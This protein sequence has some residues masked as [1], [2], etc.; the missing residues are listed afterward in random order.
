M[1][2]PQS[3]TARA[4]AADPAVAGLERPTPAGANA[5]GFGS[6]V[7]AEALR[8]LDIPYIALTPGASYR[9]LHD[10]IVNYLGNSKPQM[11]LCL[12]EEAAIAIAQ[13]YAKVTGKAMVTAVHSN[14]GLMHATMAIFNAW[15]DRMPV[16]VL[17]AT[18]P[19]DA[20]KRRPWIDWIHTSRDQGALIREYTKWD[21]QPA[22]P[23]AAREA[24]LRGTWIANTAPQG[25]VYI[26]F[27][28]EL[29]ESK[30]S[31]PLPP[32]DV[33]R[34]MPEVTTAAPAEL[35]KQAA[36]TLK[37]AKQ[38]LILAGRCS[39]SEA[40]WNARVQLA[41]A[42][43]ARVVTD[44]KIG[45]SFPTEHPLYAGAPRAISPDSVE[46]LKNVDVI[47]SLDWVDLAG[48]LR[49]YGPSPS[50]KV[51]QVSLDHRI[52]NG[53]SMDHQA[54]PAVD[55]LLSA[56]P[57]LVVPE[58]V[59]EIGKGN[60]P[61][62]VP[63]PRAKSPDKEPTGFTNEHI[64]RALAKV[65]GDRP[66]CYSGL[67]LSWDDSWVPFRHPLDYVGSNGGGGVGGGPGISVG[68][69]LALK[70]TG[71]L[72]IAICGDGDFLMGVTAVWTA[73][74]Y[75]IPMLFILANN[76]SFYNDELHQERM[77]RAR[78]RPVE[79]KWIGQRMS[80]PEVD[81][82][83]M[84]RAQGAVGFGPVLKPTDLAGVLQKAIAE[85]DAGNVAVVDVR[86][87]PGYTAVM[88]AAMTR[89]GS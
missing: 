42:L 24:I 61:H 68:V 60:K 16:I 43:G 9:G 2:P 3:A 72:P 25:P 29:Q 30:V 11:L 36:A 4:N 22:S 20:A 51:I 15:C 31:E 39:R 82:A 17:G 67:P 49:S 18:G 54:L 63:A 62:A 27:D 89:A 28:A 59:K 64:A 77:A 46:G 58:L 33:A 1:N 47:L 23:A 7:I 66:V 45:A 32:I 19:V 78:N 50:V 35:V 52:H 71:R 44:L 55:L 41:E 12:H 73:V 70:G 37:G 5:P 80:E 75:K 74:H 81:L 57:D 84:G 26:N 53:W 56:D 40:A 21:D 14:V 83:A 65:L 6:D 85:V 8:S 13:G 76:R 79:N 34:Y 88:T 86:V 69:A 87:E 10:S 38:V 48:A